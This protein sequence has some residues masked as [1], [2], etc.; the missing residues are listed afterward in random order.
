MKEL[1][2]NKIFKS[3]KKEKEIPKEHKTFSPR[4]YPARHKNQGSVWTRNVSKSM[5]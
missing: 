2:K 4:V 5:S 3:A 1:V